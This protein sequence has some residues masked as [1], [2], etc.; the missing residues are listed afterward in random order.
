MLFFLCGCHPPLLFES[1]CQL[2]NQVPELS[3]MVVPGIHI[4]I[5]Q[6]LARPPKEQSHQVPVSKHLLTTEIVLD[7]VS[8]DM[9]DPQVAL[10]PVSAP[11]FVPFLHL[12]RNVPGLK[13]LRC[14]GNRPP[15]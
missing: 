1:F 3:L 8:A 7:L 12:D 2:P 14:L 11:F 13:T 5:G 9:I 10:P 15:L 4:Y 6:L